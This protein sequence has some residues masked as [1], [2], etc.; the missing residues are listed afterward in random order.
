MLEVISHMPGFEQQ[1]WD[2]EPDSRA[3]E[4]EADAAYY[5]NFTKAMKFVVNQLDNSW[6]TFYI[7]VNKNNALVSIWGQFLQ[8]GKS[9]QTVGVAGLPPMSLAN[10][11]VDL[12]GLFEVVVMQRLTS[13]ALR[14][15]LSKY[16]D[17]TMRISGIVDGIAKA[18]HGQDENALRGGIKSL[19]WEVVTRELP[20]PSVTHDAKV[21]LVTLIASVVTATIV[22]WHK[23]N[24]YNPSVK[25]TGA[26]NYITS[27]GHVVLV[28]YCNVL[29]ALGWAAYTQDWNMFAHSVGAS[30]LLFLTNKIFFSETRVYA[31]DDRL[32]E[33]TGSTW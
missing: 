21:L 1:R 9:P 3:S 23:R 13:A 2:P 22:R 14:Q 28:S 27:M 19:T 33:V 6:R 32:L 12:A 16:N 20:S 26:S 5:G 11:T 15:N 18:F 31:S 30:S 7:R 25:R 10:L 29:W 8:L 4:L 24:V 17:Q